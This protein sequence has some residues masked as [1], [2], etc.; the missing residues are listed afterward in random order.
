MQII[1]TAFRRFSNWLILEIKKSKREFE[2]KIIHKQKLFY[3]Y[4]RQHIT[5]RV[6]TPLL[7]KQDGTL[8]ESNKDV[9]ET[10]AEYFGTV[11]TQ[12]PTTRVPVSASPRNPISLERINLSTDLI[13]SELQTLRENSSPGP[14][15]LPPKLLKLGATFL[16]S[17]VLKILQTSFFSGTL[18]PAWLQACLT[19]SL[20]KATN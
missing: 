1:H 6:S 3:K 13:E 2:S 15:D 17:P 7:N 19:P 10:L 12:S 9:A 8:C 11:Y 4:V 20:K 18:P 16:A 14:D 5:S